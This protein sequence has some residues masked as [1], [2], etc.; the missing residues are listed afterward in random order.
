[1]SQYRGKHEREMVLIQK[2]N[3]KTPHQLCQE[4]ERE[5]D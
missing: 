2:R 4:A 5:R 1:V 3:D